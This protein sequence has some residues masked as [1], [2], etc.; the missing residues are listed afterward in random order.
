M[1][2]NDAQI[3]SLVGLQ[4]I[5]VLP[6]GGGGAILKVCVPRDVVETLRSLAEPKNT[7]LKKSSPKGT[8]VKIYA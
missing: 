7:V 4:T 2:S 3:D 5:I 8:M 6:N 1:L